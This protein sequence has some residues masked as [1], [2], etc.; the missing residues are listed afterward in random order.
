[1]APLP[2]TQCPWLAWHRLYT[3]GCLPRTHSQEL[4]SLYGNTWHSY[5]STSLQAIRSSIQSPKRPKKMVLGKMRRRR[6]RESSSDEG[7]GL[8][9]PREGV[10]RKPELSGTVRYQGRCVT[11]R[12]CHPPCGKSMNRQN[13]SE[14]IMSVLKN[15][16]AALRCADSQTHLVIIIVEPPEARGVFHFSVSHE[17]VRI[18]F[19]SS[20]FIFI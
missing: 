20:T 10:G 9:C 14:T 1:M 16:R 4:A 17:S 3:F 13:D 5:I 18:L 7:T 19:L 11:G 8:A 12:G 2:L 6:R 15:D